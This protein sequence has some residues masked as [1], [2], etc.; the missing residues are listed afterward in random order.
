MQKYAYKKA[1][2]I[3]T[4]I[5]RMIGKTGKVTETIDV[6]KNEGRVAIDGDEWK[7]ISDDKSIIEKDKVVEVINIESIIITVKPLN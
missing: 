3:K 7:A 2:H 5:D 6:Y 4:N 1:A